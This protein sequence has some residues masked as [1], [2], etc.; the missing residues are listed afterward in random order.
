MKPLKNLLFGVLMLMTGLPLVQR[1]VPV[2]RE[3][4]L[5]GVYDLPIEPDATIK[6]WFD[7]SF[8]ESYNIF[9]EFSSGLRPL[10]VRINN[11]IAFS[12]FDTAQANGVII[13]KNKYLYEINYIKAWKGWDFTG[14]K[15]IDEQA[16]KAVFVNKKLREAGK[17]LLF[18]FAPGKAS[19]FPEYIPD[20]YTKKPS[21]EM[22][23]YEAYLESFR[24]KNLPLIDFNEWFV[25]M[26]DTSSYPLYPKCGIHWSSYGVA[27]AVDSLIRYLEKDRNINMVDF[28]W[29]GFDIPDSLRSP[30][31]DI[32]D[33]MNLLFTI[34][35][36]R[37]AYPRNWFG[38]EEGKVKPNA[39]VVGDSYYWNIFGSGISAR[40]FRD[41]NFW[42]YNVEAHNPQWTAPKKTEEINILEAVGN[43]DIIVIMA[44]EANLYRFPYG[45]IDRLYDAL[46]AEG[47]VKASQKLA[48]PDS[49]KEAEIAVIIQNIDTN[50]SWSES[51]RKKA[52]ERGITYYE[53]LRLDATWMWEQQQK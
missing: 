15:N 38:S 53:M 22:T 32:A 48:V 34:P 47:T 51:V 27:I 2:F 25:R 8:Q 4:P 37:M 21:G 9:A 31:Y 14:Q 42:Y 26:K 1:T 49:V 18:V 43:A 16:N 40:L 20:S 5:K 3:T 45:F 44:T 39:I 11:Q 23:N 28:G 24:H 19:F 46:A 52:K 12:V 33:G 13:G 10:F 17:T 30:D 36:Y 35:H 41:N 50:A 29:N 6:S 7:G